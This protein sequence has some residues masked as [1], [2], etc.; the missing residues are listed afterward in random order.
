[1]KL[2]IIT[3]KDPKIRQPSVPVNKFSDPKIQTLIKNMIETMDD[4]NGVGLAA[5]QVGQL[6]RLIVVKNKLST[7]VFINPEITYRSSDETADFEGCLSVPEKMVEVDR[8]KKIHLKA[9]D[10]NGKKI[11]LKAKGFLARVIQHECDHLEGKLITDY[12]R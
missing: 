2:N 10:P 8:A 12:E 1:M 9:I 4:A 7:Q 11:K 5:P 3:D 6:L